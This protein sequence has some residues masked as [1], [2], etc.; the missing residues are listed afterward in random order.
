MQ[1]DRMNG[2]CIESSFFF[3][4]FD[5]LAGVVDRIE[6]REIIHV[7]NPEIVVILLI[8]YTRTA[9]GGL[10]LQGEEVSFEP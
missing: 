3:S 8:N 4:V 10:F 7:F 9:L 2:S 1:W 5:S 6:W